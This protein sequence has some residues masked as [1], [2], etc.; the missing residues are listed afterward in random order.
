MH[1]TTICTTTDELLLLLHP[2]WPVN[3]APCGQLSGVATRKGVRNAQADLTAFS[4]AFSL[5]WRA[6]VRARATHSSLSLSRIKH[7]EAWII[8]GK[9]PTS[10]DPEASSQDL[11]KPLAVDAELKDFQLVN[12]IS[13]C[14]R[15]ASNK[16][17][18][19][20]FER[21]HR[22]ERDS[23]ERHIRTTAQ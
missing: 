22:G 9:H 17:S 19:N 23:L 21:E 13:G 7:I 16:S 8:Y 14:V 11:P 2:S 10:P 18:R 1:C 4:K 3:S 5:T 12:R 6:V 15:R 20:T